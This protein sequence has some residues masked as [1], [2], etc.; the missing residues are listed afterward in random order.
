MMTRFCTIED[1]GLI[2]KDGGSDA[3][4]DIVEATGTPAEIGAIIAH[5]LQVADMCSGDSDSVFEDDGEIVLVMTIK[6]TAQKQNFE[7]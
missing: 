5:Q 4:Y 7:P 1:A 3:A 2:A 6:I